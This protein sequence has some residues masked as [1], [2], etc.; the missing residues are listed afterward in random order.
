M[1]AVCAV[2][3]SAVVAAASVWQTRVIAN[4]LS[5]TVWPYLSFNLTV[6]DGLLRYWVENEGLGPAIVRS[7][8]VT[9]DGKRVASLR[10]VALSLG[11][12]R[13]PRGS[14]ST[15]S[16]GAG[17]VLRPSQALDIVVFQGKVARAYAAAFQRRAT[18]A[19]CYCSLLDQCW[20]L[21]SLAD[22]A[23]PVPVARCGEAAGIGA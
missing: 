4:Q 19:I 8:T 1:I 20:R 5:A 18:L 22:S 9:I 11:S 16:L 3:V 23:I 17:E 10:A 7:A 15:S 12:G 2:L 6:R 13:L 21:T 14:L